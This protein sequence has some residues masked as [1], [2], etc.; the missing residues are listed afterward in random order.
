M[1]QLKPALF[2]HFNQ[3]VIGNFVV[4]NLGYTDLSSTILSLKIIA[5]AMEDMIFCMVLEPFHFCKK[6]AYF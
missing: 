4:I 2:K 3:Y 6:E 1:G 5:T